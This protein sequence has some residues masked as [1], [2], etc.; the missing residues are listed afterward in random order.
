MTL[1]DNDKTVRCE[2]CP[3]T[4]ADVIEAAKSGW[5]W[6]TGNL[7]RAMHFCPRHAKSLTRETLWNQAC[8]EGATK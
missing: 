5:D 3:K 6:F 2:C 7:P 4:A 8:M 1:L